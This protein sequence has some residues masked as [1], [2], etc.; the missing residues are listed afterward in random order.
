MLYRPPSKLMYK[1]SLF[2]YSDS[3]KESISGISSIEKNNITQW[4]IFAYFAQVHLLRPKW[5]GERWHDEP[6]GA[7]W[8][9]GGAAGTRAHSAGCVAQG[10]TLALPLHPVGRYPLGL[11]ARSNRAVAHRAR[12]RHCFP[13]LHL[14]RPRKPYLYWSPTSY[15]L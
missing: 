9:G 10:G 12:P 15:F 5:A 1:N 13:S 7:R 4:L 14:R 6:G 8:D 3:F 11:G 2:M